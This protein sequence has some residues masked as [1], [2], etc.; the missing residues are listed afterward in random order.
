MNEL[1]NTEDRTEFFR[2][3][4]NLLQYASSVSRLFWPPISKDK[5]ATKRS[6]ARGDYLRNVLNMNDGHILH[7]RTFRDHLA[8]YDERLD[9]WAETSAHKAFVDNNIGPPSAFSGD[10]I[11]DKD[12]MRHYDPHSNKFFFRGEF[13]NIREL[14]DGVTEVHNTAVSRLNILQ[15][16]KLDAN[17]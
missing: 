9:D 7:K 13:L 2:E 8:H 11:N 15:Y 1:L 5:S 16:T 10:A 14:I 6:K 3:L 4:N 17:T 12:I